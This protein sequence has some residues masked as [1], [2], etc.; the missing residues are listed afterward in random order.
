MSA[1][2]KAAVSAGSAGA[3]GAGTNAAIQAASKGITNVDG[4]EAALAGA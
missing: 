2:G 1:L 3:I 4:K